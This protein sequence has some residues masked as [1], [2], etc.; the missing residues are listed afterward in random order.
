[1]G[2]M[3]HTAT[4]FNQPIG[5]W[6]TSNVISMST[7]FYKAASFNQPIGNWNTSNANKGL[8]FC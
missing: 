1:M 6:N 5:N 8:K 2:G 3:F 4:S 7:M